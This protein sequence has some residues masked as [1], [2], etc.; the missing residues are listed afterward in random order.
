MYKDLRPSLTYFKIWQKPQAP[1]VVGK[2]M[3]CHILTCMWCCAAETL[4]NIHGSLADGGFLLLY[5]TT[6]AFTTCLWG[7]DERTWKFTDEREYGLWMAKP[8]WHRLWTEAG[9]TQ[10]VEHWCVSVGI[11]SPFCND[12]ISHPKFYYVHLTLP[13]AIPM[14]CWCPPLLGLYGPLLDL[15]IVCNHLET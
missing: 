8:R 10:I 13:P 4:A 7:L 12:L 6:A 1:M 9:F 11:T 2:G 5:E 14:S 3:L 15:H